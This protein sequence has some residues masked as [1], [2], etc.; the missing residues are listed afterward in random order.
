MALL[1]EQGEALGVVVVGSPVAEDRDGAPVRDGD[2][3]PIGG[4]LEGRLA[5]EVL[6][7]SGDAGGRPYDGVPL[8]EEVQDRGQPVAEV[9]ANL[10][11]AV[12]RGLHQAGELVVRL[13]VV[14]RGVVL[15]GCRCDGLVE[16]GDSVLAQ[17][18]NRLA[19]LIVEH[20]VGVGLLL[21]LLH[22]LRVLVGEGL[23]EGGHAVEDV[24]LVVA[25]EAEHRAAPVVPTMIL[26]SCWLL[27]PGCQFL[28]ASS[29]LLVAGPAGLDI[30]YFF[31]GGSPMTRRRH[32]I[33][34]RL[35]EGADPPSNTL[36]RRQVSDGIVRGRKHF[37]CKCPA[38]YS[39]V[40]VAEAKY[41]GHLKQRHEEQRVRGER[42]RPGSLNEKSSVPGNR[43][44][45]NS[46]LGGAGVLGQGKSA[47]VGLRRFAQAPATEMMRASHLRGWRRTRLSA[48]GKV[49]RT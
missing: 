16:T 13:V 26:A 29:W 39:P 20:A 18:F 9:R 43:A 19:G 27:V 36:T 46:R 22:G 44:F 14:G 6:E 47:G 40:Q 7:Q 41:G 37:P 24:G 8:A 45:L 48:E 49:S 21:E 32:L 42:K 30:F 23:A 11:S 17:L 33:R 28:V 5:F 2:L 10:Q 38:A 4:G 31:G 1:D 15:G 34:R 12:H 3:A 25:V 35:W